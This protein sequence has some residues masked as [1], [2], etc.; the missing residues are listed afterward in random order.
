MTKVRKAC[1]MRSFRAGFR[2]ANRRRS[3]APATVLSRGSVPALRQA[4][5]WRSRR[6]QPDMREPIGSHSRA[7]HRRIT[8]PA[9]AFPLTGPCGSG[10]PGLDAASAGAGGRADLQAVGAA[11]AATGLAAAERDRAGQQ[12]HS[13]GELLDSLPCAAVRPTQSGSERKRED[14]GS[15]LA[16]QSRSGIREEQER[17]GQR[18]ID[19]GADLTPLAVASFL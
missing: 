10:E 18:L 5:H 14:T 15:C 6:I 9:D 11:G 16:Q 17:L 13:H 8:E 4:R 19:I 2:A 7:G 12:R 1:R 3:L